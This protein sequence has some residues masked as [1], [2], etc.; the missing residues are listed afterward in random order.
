MLTM[1]KMTNCMAL[2]T[3]LLIY[4]TQIQVTQTAKQNC[5]LLK[6]KDNM[7]YLS[8]SNKKGEGYEKRT[9]IR[10]AK[11][12]KPR[13]GPQ[14]ERGPPGLPGE[15]GNEGKRGPEGPMGPIGPT[16]VPGPRGHKGKPGPKG[17]RG[18]GGPMGAQGTPGVPGNC[19]RSAP[20]YS[21]K[22]EEYYHCLPGP[23]GPQGIKGDTGS[24]GDS[25]VTGLK[26]NPGEKG[27]QGPRG[28]RGPVGMP[29]LPGTAARIECYDQYTEW[30]SQYNLSEA[31]SID[32]FFC[33][34]GQFL[35]GF[36][37]ERDAL[38]ERYH[39]VCCGLA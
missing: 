24:K 11:D 31:K 30:V 38:Q 18:D 13:R 19:L 35:Q 29:G 12:K 27:P 7:F 20:K 37:R 10:R 6:N 39:Y 32:G 4:L 14:G 25:G 8:C 33:P 2:M 28:R 36:K 26:G 9:S 17:Q 15:D 22:A 23:Q 3:T 16:G 1:N 21:N 5:E 34:K